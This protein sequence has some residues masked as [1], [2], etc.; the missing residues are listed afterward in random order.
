MECRLKRNQQAFFLMDEDHFHFLVPCMIWR[1]L[2]SVCVK[3]QLQVDWDTWLIYAACSC[4]F[5]NV[6]LEYGFFASQKFLDFL[7]MFISG[8]W[9]PLWH[10]DEPLH[11][12]QL[13]VKEAL[14]ELVFYPKQLRTRGPWVLPSS[15]LILHRQGVLFG[16]IQEFLVP[17]CLVLLGSPQP[18]QQQQQ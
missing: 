9:D 15:P 4:T 12:A 1:E 8:D 18:Q 10:R 3:S 2:R 13:R 11:F 7:V 17:F 14:C 5:H 6:K 16:F